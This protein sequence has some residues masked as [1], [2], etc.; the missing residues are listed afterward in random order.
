MV[1]KK[2]KNTLR[3]NHMCTYNP[4][5]NLENRKIVN[6]KKNIQMK[7]FKTLGKYKAFC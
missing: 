4:L 2:L 5:R 7:V 3:D 6:A 1:I